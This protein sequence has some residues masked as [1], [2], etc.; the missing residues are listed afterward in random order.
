MPV[1]HAAKQASPEE[2]VAVLAPV[3]ERMNTVAG[4]VNASI[5]KV[6]QAQKLAA[7]VLQ[8]GAPGPM[9]AKLDAIRQVLVQVAQRAAA[10]K[11]HLEAALQQVRAVGDAGN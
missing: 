4:G 9:L 3:L 1:A 7:S 8:G 11:Q 2:T 10:A 5:E 6:N